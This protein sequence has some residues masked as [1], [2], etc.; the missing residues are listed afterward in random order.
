[1]IDKHTADLTSKGRAMQ[2]RTIA[3]HWLPE[4]F[5]QTPRWFVRVLQSRKSGRIYYGKPERAL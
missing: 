4:L 5:C 3:K 1:M 2:F